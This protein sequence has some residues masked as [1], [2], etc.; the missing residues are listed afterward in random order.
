MTPTRRTA[1]GFALPLEE[2]A[3]AGESARTSQAGQRQA[4]PTRVDEA[5]FLE[6]RELFQDSE[7]SLARLGSQLEYVNDLVIS[8]ATKQNL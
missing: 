2:N 5:S 8:S 1:F 4:Q 6:R 7:N 3:W